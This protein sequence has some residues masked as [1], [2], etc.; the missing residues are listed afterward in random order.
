MKELV[1]AT[2]NQEEIKT[3]E[4]EG[5]DAYRAREDDIIQGLIN[6]ADF[7]EETIQPIEIIRNG[8]CFFS[9]RVQPLTEEDYNS[10][11]KKHTKY[12]R[13]KQLGLK[14]PEETNSVK[15]RAEII[16]KATLQEDRQKLWDNKKVWE[17]LNAKDIQIMNG[18]DVIEYTLMAGEKERV[19]KVIDEI[20]GYESDI[21]EVAKN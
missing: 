14:M 11:K 12:V 17:A 15:Y 10:C 20:S 5:N 16:Y 4:G 1:R 2:E 18:L 6:A 19:I 3:V 7:K 9:F 13:N 21:E 8:K